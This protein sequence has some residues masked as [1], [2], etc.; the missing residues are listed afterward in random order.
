[1][2]TRNVLM[3]GILATTLFLPFLTSSYM[4]HIL[5]VCCYYI[6]LASSWNLLA[7]FTG[8]FSFGTVGFSMVGAY[9]SGLLCVYLGLPVGL[10]ILAGILTTG[11]TGYLIGV[12]CLRLRGSYLLLVTFAFAV[13]VQ[14]I[15]WVN[16]EITRAAM[17]LQVPYLFGSYNSPFNYYSLW[18]VAL[19]TVVII[20]LILNTRVGLFI[21]AIRDSE[22]AAMVLGVNV[23]RWKL[24]AFV[25]SSIMAGVAGSVFGH[26]IGLISPEV[27]GLLQ[28]GLVTTM[29]VIG[30]DATIIGPVLGAILI[31]ISSEAIRPIGDYR[32]LFFGAMMIVMARFVKGGLWD[33]I[34][35]LGARAVKSLTT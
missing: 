11:A 1:M 3:I 13:I 2:N 5:I 16:W 24:F 32:F 17:G 7:G 28:M 21:K 27:M 29:V 8:Q 18:G 30:G 22:E 19:A 35:K 12:L 33:V 6:M 4:V 23:V 25:V 14:R 15:I 9:T 10:G 31:E 20:Y 26:Y 34:R